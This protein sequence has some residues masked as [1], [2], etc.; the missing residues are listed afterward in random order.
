MEGERQL[1]LIAAARAGDTTAFA[2][3]AESHRPRL[4][5]LAM[6]MVDESEE[7]ED[8]VQEALLHA[9]LGLTQLRDPERFGGWLA[10]S[11]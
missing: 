7:A 4:W 8:V 9:Y 11:S 1:E 10:P 5:L 2:E 6:R 3:L